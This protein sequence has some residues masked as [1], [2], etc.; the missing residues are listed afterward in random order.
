MNT[1]RENL[2]IYDLHVKPTYAV[3]IPQRSPGRSGKSSRQ[4]ENEINLKDNSHSGKMSPKAI[5]RLSNAVNWLVASA[6]T[7]TIFDK[8]TNKR[9]SFKINFVTLTLPTT[10]HDISDHHFK[11]KL[12]HNFINTCRYKFDLK[13]FV[14]KVEAQANGNIHAHFTTDTFIHWKDL[15]R[16]WNRILIKNGLMNHY[17]DKHSC[18]SFADYC[19]AYDPQGKRDPEQ[20]RKAYDHGTATNWQD[21]N[22]TDVHAVW[23]VKDIAAYLAKYMGKAEEDRRTIKGRLWGCSY[24]LS[25][26]NKLVLELH[27]YHDEDLVHDL[28]DQRIKWKPIEGIDKLSN[29]PF[30]IGDLFFFKIDHWG[31]VIKGRLLEKFNEHRFNI[32]HN[33]DV[34]ALRSYHVAE[35]EPPPALVAIMPEVHTPTAE[36]LRLIS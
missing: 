16:V 35:L 1:Q 5:R 33:I 9:Y 14:W 10:D 30:S 18:M 34:Q 29:K 22:T 23:S 8:T 7:K 26:Q 28:Y 15:R 12:L 24:N 2:P 36:Q 19:Q 3:R 27:G 25:D 21:P 32:R 4:K 13:N 31:S 6:A 11:S 20:I 17:Q